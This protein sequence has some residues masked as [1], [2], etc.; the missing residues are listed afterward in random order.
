MTAP[1]SP[2][3]FVFFDAGGTLLR[4]ARPVGETYAEIASHYGVRADA[5]ALDRAFRNAFQTMRLPSAQ[6]GAVSRPGHDRAWWFDLVARTWESVGYPDHFALEDYFD[7]VFRAFAQ[8][9]LWRVFGDTWP[10][11]ERLEAE[12]IGCG[13]LSNWDERL[14]PVLE[15]L[16][17]ADRMNPVVISQEVGAEKPHPSIFQAA[18]Q[19]CG[20]SGKEIALIGDDPELDGAGARQAGWRF[21]QLDRPDHDLVDLLDEAL[22]QG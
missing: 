20:F 21:L 9:G 16:D 3:R 2:I 14:Y 22:G 1:N 4:T 10:A 17:L 18:E 11:L 8:P 15:G 13:I 12:G 6:A 7:E 19:A 5:E